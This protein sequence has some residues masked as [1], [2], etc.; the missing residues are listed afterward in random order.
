MISA[1]LAGFSGALYAH[2]IR[3]ISPEML[4]LG[5]TFTI[6]TMVMVGGLGTFTGPIIGAV[7]LTVLSEALRFFEEA[8]NVDIRLVIYGA[9][10]VATI[11]F[12]RKGVVASSASC[13][14]G[15]TVR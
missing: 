11:I 8:I 3:L 15:K 7:L 12:M 2:Y 13:S 4:G 14:D 5:E 10:L 9:L 6:L 1:F